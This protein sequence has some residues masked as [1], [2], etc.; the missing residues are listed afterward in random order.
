[1]TVPVTVA[2]TPAVPVA[3][4]QQRTQ[5]KTG[6]ATYT[7][8]VVNKSSATQIFGDV[9]KNEGNI[10][11]FPAVGTA[12]TPGQS[13]NY[14][15][16]SEQIPSTLIMQTL[17]SG[18][19]TVAG[20]L[21][22]VLLDIHDEYDSS[23]PPKVQWEASCEP[24][25]ACSV[26]QGNGG[27][28]HLLDSPGTV[29]VV[30]DSDTETRE[31]VAQSVVASSQPNTTYYASPNSAAAT[32]P[33]AVTRQPPLGG[34]MMTT[35]GNTTYLVGGPNTTWT[36]TETAALTFVGPTPGCV[37]CNAPRT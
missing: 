7:Y 22:T 21:T 16:R 14:K 10:L 26:P 17:S 35:I 29:V 5:A 25:A 36:P 11:S 19:G 1:M 20:I 30:P 32:A 3:V 28:V 8:T 34:V 37:S 13:A 4:D 23:Y 9:V 31:Y 15:V 12:L 6:F 27:T 33:G 2:A 24:T 18:S